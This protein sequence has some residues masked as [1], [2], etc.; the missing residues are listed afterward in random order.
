MKPEAPR[1]GVVLAGEILG[2]PAGR[3]ARYIELS[4]TISQVDSEFVVI[5]EEGELTA[6]ELTNFARAIELHPEADILYAD[7]TVETAMGLHIVSKPVFSPERLRNQ[8]YF[9][10]VVVYRNSLLQAISGLRSQLEGAA[11]Y[12]L[13]LRASRQAASVV[14]IPEPLSSSIKG[15]RLGEVGVEDL[16]NVRSAL[17][18]HLTATG[19]GVVESVHLSGVH[20]TMRP[21]HGAPLVSIVIPTRG[22]W[23]FTG[24]HRFSLVLDAV[25][26]V[27]KKSTYENYEIVV[28]F[29]SVADP[30][31][32]ESLRTVAGERLRLIEWMHTF[33]FSSK[34]NLGVVNSGGEYVLILNDDVQLITPDW[35]ER[36]LALVQLPE[37]GMAG[38]MLYFD[39][40]TI[41]HAGHHYWRGDATHIGMFRDRTDAGPLNGYRV[42]REV[43]GVTAAC[44][45]M[46]RDVFYA[47]GGM[48]SLLPGAFNDVDLCMKVTTAGYKI[49]WTPH[50]ELYHFESKTRDA[51]VQKYEVD[52]AWGRWGSRMHDPRYWPYPS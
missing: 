10:T 8:F 30:D 23:G 47:V 46:P 25:T 31:V 41:Q 43:M 38:C 13:A 11:L 33:N 7:E 22:V 39:D 5:V 3:P 34:I 36:M 49:Y 50:A 19:G 32:I 1:L 24:E 6:A 17:N 12:D 9:G 20:R 15:P 48:S 28:V 52:T 35:I 37:A 18:E 27:V 2:D 4:E 44:A 21:V 42:E 14:H 29:D 45:M 51:S 16:E 40:E 26:G